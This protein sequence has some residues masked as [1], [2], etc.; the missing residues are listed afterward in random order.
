VL[1]DFEDGL[2]LLLILEVGVVDSVG[3]ELS[4]LVYLDES[5]LESKSV[6]C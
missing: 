5:S 1:G 2:G 3:V 4:Q 6:L